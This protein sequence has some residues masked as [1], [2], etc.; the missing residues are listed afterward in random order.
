MYFS[1]PGGMQDTV[2]QE[3]NVVI[4]LEWRH[5]DRLAEQMIQKR[6]LRNSTKDEIKAVVAEVICR[7][8]QVVL[9]QENM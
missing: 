7:E 8:E 2:V 9:S 6:S 1:R 3:G 4:S 5:G